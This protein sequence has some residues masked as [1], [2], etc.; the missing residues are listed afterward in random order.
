MR[1][2]TEFAA[3]PGIPF[4]RLGIHGRTSP[5][6]VSDAAALLGKVDAA[7]A[8]LLGKVGAARDIM[9]VLSFPI[10]C[11]CVC[12][13]HRR[14]AS[15]NDFVENA[16]QQWQAA[17]NPRNDQCTLPLSGAGQKDKKATERGGRVFMTVRKPWVWGRG[18]PAGSASVG[19]GAGCPLGGLAIPQV[20]MTLWRMRGNSGKPPRTQPSGAASSTLNS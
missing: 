2:L 8:V 17:S 3:Q 16:W 20:L 19:P 4:A 15:F 13:S 10:M 5:R 14:S 9:C 7:R 6:E 11:V 18:R 12:R 1:Y